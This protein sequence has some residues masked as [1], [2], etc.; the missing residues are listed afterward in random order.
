MQQWDR[1]AHLHW[2]VLAHSTHLRG[3]GTWDPATGESGRVTVTL[4]TGIPEDVC[5][6]VGLGYRDP[7]ASISTSARTICSSSRTRGRRCS[8]YGDARVPHAAGGDRDE[9]LIQVVQRVP[10]L[11]RTHVP[12]LRRAYRRGMRRSPRL[13]LAV[14]LLTGACTSGGDGGSSPTPGRSTA[15]SPGSATAAVSAP[16]ALLSA[17]P[18]ARPGTATVLAKDLAVPWGVAFLPDGSALVSERDSHRIVRVTA[19][20]KVTPVGTVPGV[21]DDSGEGGLLGIALSPRFARTSSCTP[22]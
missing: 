15:S 3:A 17:G 10:L 16:P 9:H 19:Q 7:P 6:S 8:G 20:G 21:Q 22:T 5:R 13:V 11:A 18:S 4:A 12:T 14:A 2:G 1:F